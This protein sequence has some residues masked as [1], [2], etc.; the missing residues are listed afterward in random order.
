MASTKRVVSNKAKAKASGKAFGKAMGSPK[1]KKP[2]AK[3]KTK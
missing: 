2:A 3:K 1:K